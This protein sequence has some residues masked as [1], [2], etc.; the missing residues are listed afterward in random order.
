[1]EGKLADREPLATVSV[2]QA[3]GPQPAARTEADDSFKGDSETRKGR[4]EAEWEEREAARDGKWQT[5]FDTLEQQVALLLVELS[6]RKLQSQGPASQGEVVR[7]FKVSLSGGAGRR[8]LQ[9]VVACDLAQMKVRTDAIHSR[10]CDEP[11]ED[12]AGGR[13][14][15]CNADCAAVLVP[16]SAPSR[17]G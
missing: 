9:A 3:N 13:L 5:R 4:E 12:C 11:G 10:C 14:S 6:R 8:S 17:G 15:A 7:L 16:L 1:L 2:E